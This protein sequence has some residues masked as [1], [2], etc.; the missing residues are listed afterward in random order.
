MSIVAN[1]NDKLDIIS[2]AYSGDYGTCL[3]NLKYRVDN[4]HNTTVYVIFSLKSL[5]NGRDLNLITLPSNYVFTISNTRFGITGVSKV[6]NFEI[7]KRYIAVLR[8]PSGKIVKYSGF[9]NKNKITTTNA[10]QEISKDSWR[11]GGYN[12][13]ISYKSPGINIDYIGF[14]PEG[15]TDDKVYSN[16]NYLAK[17][18][19]V[20]LEEPS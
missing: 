11:I 19:E 16:M 4:Y 17:F 12:N 7:N 9:L 3:D 14:C 13:S 10:N 5:G 2:S 1:A 8:I 18:F 6:F 15:H 20:D